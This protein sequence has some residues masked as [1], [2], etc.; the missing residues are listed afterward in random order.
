N[1]LLYL[2]LHLSTRTLFLSHLPWI[3]VRLVSRLLRLDGVFPLALISALGRLKQ[4]AR[5]RSRVSGGPAGQKPLEK[6]L[7]DITH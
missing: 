4:V 3:F 6:I 2:W 1:R 5:L 7:A